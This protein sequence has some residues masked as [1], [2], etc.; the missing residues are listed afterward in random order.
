MIFPPPSKERIDRALW[1]G[2]VEW[3]ADNL[4]CGCC[5]YEHTFF[6]CEARLWGGCRG[7]NEAEDPES[8]RAH[9]GMTYAQ[10]YGEEVA[11]ETVEPEVEDVPR[12]VLQPKH[13]DD[14]TD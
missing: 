5:C 12:S 13:F 8:W 11:I 7:R 1:E 6:G 14:R 3:L 2:D 10:F 9:Y 4:P